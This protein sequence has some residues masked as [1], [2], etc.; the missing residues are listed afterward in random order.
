MGKTAIEWATDVWNP[1]TGCHKVSEGCRNCYAKVLHDMRHK[2][3]LDARMVPLQYAEP[4]EKIQMHPKR[5]AL[6]EGWRKPRRIFVNSMSDLFHKDVT[7]EFI[8]QVFAAMFDAGRHTFMILTKRAERMAWYLS[9]DNPR[10]SARKV[11]DITKGPAGK[12]DCD[13]YWPLDNVWL[14][15]SVENQQAAD[16]RIPWLLKTPAAVRFVSC[17]P[18][19]GPVDL[20]PAEIAQWPNMTDAWMPNKEEPD[21]WKYWMHKWNGISWV[22]AGGESGP[23][24]RPMHPDWARG[25]RD[26]CQAAGVPFFFKQWGEWTSEFPQHKNLTNTQMTY[27]HNETFYRIGKKL[28]GRLLDGQE[29]NQFPEIKK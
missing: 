17:E 24:A 6:P 29:W 8:D 23:G 22:I 15:T 5:L 27:Q 14:G 3:Y 18:L 28:A 13:M 20:K 1:V 26:Q 21:D 7:D 10:Y 12:F 25:L 11:F 9:P 19:L 4:F 2:A 16:E